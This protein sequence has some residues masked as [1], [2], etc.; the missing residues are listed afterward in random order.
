MKHFFCNFIFASILI[1]ISTDAY[2]KTFYAI[3]DGAWN[4][5]ENW[6]TDASGI[7]YTNVNNECPK[8]G[9]TAV[10]PSGKSITINNYQITVASLTL[11]GDLIITGSTKKLLTVSGVMSGDGRL[12]C[13]A[14]DNVS[15]ANN[16][17]LPV[18][19]T[20]FIG[21]DVTISE[22]TTFGNIEVELLAADKVLSVKANTTVNG[23]LAVNKGQ[24]AISGA[25]RVFNVIG[26][27]NVAQ[28]ATLKSDNNANATT[29]TMNVSGNFINNGKVLFAAGSQ[30]DDANKLSNKV[31]LYFNGSN[32]SRFEMNGSTDL[33]RV[34]CQK[35]NKTSMLTMSASSASYF[36]LFGA[37]ANVSSWQFQPMALISGVLKLADNI[38]IDKWGCGT[39][40]SNIQSAG[41]LVIPEDATLW[42][43]GANVKAGELSL[44]DWTNYKSFIELNGTLKITSGTIETPQKSLGIRYGGSKDKQ[45]ELIIDGGTI[46]SSRLYPSDES[47]SRLNYTQHGGQVRLERE[48]IVPN[49]GSTFHMT[50]TDNQMFTMTGGTL[51]LATT[52]ERGWNGGNGIFIKG[53]DGL[54]NVTGGTV[55]VNPIGNFGITCAAPF[56]NLTIQ[57]NNGGNVSMYSFRNNG[58]ES[59][60]LTVKNNLVLESSGN[61]GAVLNITSDEFYLYIGRN[62][63]VSAKSKIV[64]DNMVDAVFNGSS[65]GVVNDAS[66]MCQF[67]NCTIDKATSATKLTVADNS[68]P[69]LVS[70][71]L[72]VNNGSLVGKVE[73]NKRAAQ[74]VTSAYGNASGFDECDLILNKDGN[75]AK[76]GSN[77]KL[78]SVV[79][80]NNAQFN[81]QTYNLELLTVPTGFSQSK[82]FAVAGNYSDGG[83]TLPIAAGNTV[84]F[85]LFTNNNYRPATV[86]SKSGAA[87]KL[88]VVAGNGYHP[89]SVKKDNNTL[90]CYW[91]SFWSGNSTGK[92]DYSFNVTG[93]SAGKNGFKGYRLVNNDWQEK[94]D[95]NQTVLSFN[96]VESPFDGDFTAGKTGE[97]FKDV[98][99]YYS[100]KSGN[101]TDRIWSTTINGAAN[102]Q[103]SATDIVVVQKNH[104]VTI[105]GG[106]DTLAISLSINEG[107][108]VIVTSDSRNEISG[109]IDGDGTL[110]YRVKFN[111]SSYNDFDNYLDGNHSAFCKSK[112]ATWVYELESHW[113]KPW[114][115][116]MFYLPK[117]IVEYPNLTFTSTYEGD[118]KAVTQNMGSMIINGDL[119]LSSTNTNGVKRPRITF[120]AGGLTW[121]GSLTIS[122][123]IITDESTYLNFALNG[124]SDQTKISC[125]GDIVNNGD[126]WINQITEFHHYGSI[127]QNGVFA[128]ATNFIFNGEGSV[129][130]SGK[131]VDPDK[132]RF[133]RISV[134]KQNATDTVLFAVPIHNYAKDKD[135]ILDLT[136]GTMHFSHADLDLKLFMS[137]QSQWSGNSNIFKIPSASTLIV[138][139]GGKVAMTNADN[140]V[141]IWL[142]GGLILKNGSSADVTGGISYTASGLSTVAVGEKCSL[143]AK[144][145]APFSTTGTLNFNLSASTGAV[146][147]SGGMAKFANGVLDIRGGQYVQAKNSVVTIKGVSKNNNNVATVNFVP[148]KSILGL[149]SKIVMD[150]G[151]NTA[152]INAASSLM[153]ADILDPTKM[154]SELEFDGALSIQSKFNS[155]GN[156]LTLNSDMLISGNGNYLAEKN[157]TYFSGSYDQ[158]LS[159]TS[160]N[161]LIFNNVTKNGGDATV[162][163]SAATVEGL[164]TVNRGGIMLN[165]DWKALS[166]VR[167]ENKSEVSGLST[168]SMCGTKAQ[169]LFCEGTIGLLEVN[170]INGVSSTYLQSLPIAINTKLTLKAGV[171]NIGGNLLELKANASVENGGTPFGTNKMIVTNLSFSDRG[172]RKYLPSDAFNLILPMGSEGKYTPITLNVNSHSSQNGAYLTIAPSDEPSVSLSKVGNCLNYY[173][174]VNSSN[175][176]ALNATFTFDGLLSDADN[177]TS[178]YKAAML[179]LSATSWRVFDDA[180][181][182][183]N[184][185]MLLTFNFSKGYDKDISGDYTAGTN[186]PNIQAYI[187]IADG[188]ATNGTIWKSYDAETQTVSGNALKLSKDDMAGCILYVNHDVAVSENGL[189]LCRVN[190]M[191][192]G[193]LKL[194]TTKNHNFGNL[195]GVGKLQLESGS[196]PSTSGYDFYGK[197]GGT[198]EFTGNTNYNVLS[199]LSYA[200]NVIFSGTGTRTL[201]AD[202][203]IFDVYGLLTLNG[204]TVDMPSPIRLNADLEIKSGLFTGNSCIE[205]AGESKQTITSSSSET[206]FDVSW[207]VNNAN[208]VSVSS[209]INIS[210]TLSLVKGLV[211]MNGKIMKVSNTAPSAVQGGSASSYIDGTL[212]KYIYTSDATAFPVGNAG[213]Y[214]SAMVN[215]QVAGYYDVTYHNEEP[216]DAYNMDDDLES[217]SDNEY[218]VINNDAQS[219]AKIT[220]RWDSRSGITLNSDFS[221]ATYESIWKA[222]GINNATIQGNQTSGSV[223][224]KDPISC[225]NRFL[226]FASSGFISEYSWTGKVNSDWFNKDN[227]ASGACPTSTSDVY[228]S[229]DCPNMPIIDSETEV[230]LANSVEIEDNASLTL[231]R[232]MMTLYGDMYIDGT[233]TIHHHSDRMASFINKGSVNGRITIKRTFK[234]G[235]LWYVGSASSNGNVEASGSA[236][237]SDR[238]KNVN[239]GSGNDA[240][241]VYKETAA[242]E[243]YNTSYTFASNNWNLGRGSN[244]GTIG[245]VTLDK[246]NKYR[247]ITQYEDKMPKVGIQAVRLEKNLYGWNLMTNPYPFTL[248]LRDNIFTNFNED[249]ISPVIWFRTYSA[250]NGYYFT[251]FNIVTKV[252]VNMGDYSIAEGGYTLAPYQSFFVKALVDDARLTIDATKSDHIKRVSLKSVSSTDESDVLRLTVSSSEANTDETA[253]VFRAGGTIELNNVDAVKKA[254][255]ST[256]NLIYSVKGST[257]NAIG[258]YPEVEY[259]GNNVLPLG[260]QISSKSATATIKA[261]N[262]DMFAANTD[263]FL[264]DEV[265]GEIV[266]LRSEPTYTFT[267]KAGSSSVDRFSLILNIKEKSENGDATQVEDHASESINITAYQN[268]AVV[269]I[270]Q[271]LLKSNAR[272]VVYDMS[273]RMLKQINASEVTT[274]IDL[275]DSMGIFIVEAKAGNKSKR[276][277]IQSTSL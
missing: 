124:G 86:I 206:K 275:G 85:P 29:C 134:D 7:V 62:L 53:G 5:F 58:K 108:T 245:M 54:N 263:V 201:R 132:N 102:G 203:V 178:A 18:G 243:G 277:K 98:E 107:G 44:N 228:I 135:V 152:G 220:L 249:E 133:K 200:N 14:L 111:Y 114:G 83:L 183:K 127:T 194:G 28:G 49:A 38:N 271:E 26:D 4:D 128:S 115:G 48:L 225:S 173:W 162:V 151:S 190:I 260:V 221:I 264:L 97:I 129:S 143:D 175:V 118:T 24:L 167:I 222:V 193:V 184:G 13:Y 137:G 270:P 17:F 90:N 172:I 274:T 244:G 180:L 212:S 139:N 160:N 52:S 174:T 55:I 121:N 99:T 43:A 262:I 120:D 240:L 189:H 117:S 116:E 101:W 9:D 265:T 148:T 77:I 149:G 208:G 205:F 96:D 247:S 192:Q 140:E 252:G 37:V 95:C 219:A 75:V 266:D 267:M 123:D 79:F 19:T 51:Y 73:L 256:Y 238:L 185:R 223:Q 235:R 11:K 81:L 210:K 136:K 84:V 157:T 179:P 147:L 199:Q 91:R 181:S 131:S 46:I 202:G 171:F 41:A 218:W 254:E 154:M 34:I 33:Y 21:N 268:R 257:S 119:K 229:A 164:L 125:K 259:V 150:H 87:G 59:T 217:I 224:T 10:V 109:T 196:L 32:D 76:L 57:G 258:L 227:W 112:K 182:V 187:S 72:L 272:I 145:I 216:T 232:S 242:G 126:I 237:Y 165:G 255:K 269:T 100:I 2:S 103:P 94:G 47:N 105:G 20:R 63:S 142:D 16:A 71:N 239:A 141:G 74:T 207:R 1:F 89:A 177:Y 25:G 22:A 64:S 8:A 66:G 213:R 70:G 241:K 231:D 69:L 61:N 67:A 92:L 146:T 161:S 215:P 3:N 88:T 130:V 158:K 204:P 56:Y 230:A 253:L 82:C 163:A 23:N 195:L 31:E 234:T 251:T 276:S 42:I 110:V 261:T 45:A 30:Y 169:S 226:T 122:G 144:F 156:D 50:A 159:N 214:G 250:A 236:D 104:K 80:N 68:N 246:N 248:S 40:Y 168:L 176:K 113:I 60:S 211:Y 166:D 65:N 155:T 27:V 233:F 191:E 36:K 188:N 273:G 106:N 39:N 15:A 138:D 186:F 78:N 170:N 35:G 198:L 6:T 12:S 93:S 197:N 209:D 153:C